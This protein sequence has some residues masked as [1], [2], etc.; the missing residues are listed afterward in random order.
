[1]KYRNPKRVLKRQVVEAF[2]APPPVAAPKSSMQYN[3][4][5]SS[6]VNGIKSMRA[7]MSQAN[8]R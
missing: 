2:V 3:K 1:M 6:R 8:E 4:P 5:S 7:K